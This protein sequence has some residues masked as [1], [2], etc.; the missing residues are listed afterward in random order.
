[1]DEKK[2]IAKLADI[3][4]KQQKIITK[5]AQAAGLT[6]DGAKPMSNPS[7]DW[8][9]VTAQVASLLAASPTAKG[10]AVQSAH[11]SKQSGSVDGRLKV[12]MNLLTDPKLNTI[13]NQLRQ[14]LAGKNVGGVQ[15]SQNPQD[16]E[17]IAET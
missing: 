9:D 12:P 4:Q 5:L 6:G 10:V 16:I 13:M 17:F 14:Q 2:V 8:V 7:D 15:L 1:M 11:A 3:V